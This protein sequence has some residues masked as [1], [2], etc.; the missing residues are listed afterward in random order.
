MMISYVYGKT[1]LS[2]LPQSKTN[3]QIKSLICQVL[4]FDILLCVRATDLGFTALSRIF[5]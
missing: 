5:H 4:S 2:R 1:P 3:S